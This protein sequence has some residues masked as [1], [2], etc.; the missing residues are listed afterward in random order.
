LW[1]NAIVSPPER[2]NPRIEDR[3]VGLWADYID[4]QHV[5]AQNQDSKTQ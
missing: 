1:G 2:L 4:L 3:I 5:R